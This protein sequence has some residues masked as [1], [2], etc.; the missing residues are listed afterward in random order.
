MGCI[1]VPLDDRHSASVGG[2]DSG[3][4]DL[5]THTDSQGQ[6]LNHPSMRPM[7]LLGS[8]ILFIGS[9]MRLAD[10]V[11]VAASHKSITPPPCHY[12]NV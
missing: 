11:T 10:C 5:E 7:I 1:C 2:S 6:P 3:R 4:M 12:A 9:P 8:S